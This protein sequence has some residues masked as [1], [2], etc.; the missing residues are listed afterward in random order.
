[1]GGNLFAVWNLVW[2]CMGNKMNDS[3]KNVFLVFLISIFV[4]FFIFV[5][6]RI[7]YNIESLTKETKL[8]RLSLEGELQE[9]RNSFPSGK[10]IERAIDNLRSKP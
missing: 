8:L 9:L 7:S 2:L 10:N 5:S 1:M 4:A 6:S 3:D